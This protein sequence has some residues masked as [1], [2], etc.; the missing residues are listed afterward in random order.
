MKNKILVIGLV[1][2][3]LFSLSINVEKTIANPGSTT[4]DFDLYAGYNLITIPVENNYTASSLADNITGFNI[5]SRWDTDL[6]QYEDYIEGFSG[7]EHD[8]QIVDGEGYYVMVESN[9]QFSVTG[10]ELSG[11]TVDLVEE[12]N[13]LGWY[14]SSSTT[15]SA[16]FNSI[17]G[18]I[19]V[20]VFDAINQVYKNYR[21]PSDPDFVISRGMGY[22]VEISYDF[23]IDFY[24]GYNLITI[25]VENDYT[26]STLASE[27]TGCTIVSEWNH[28]NQMYDDYIVGFSGP[29][30]DFT[31]KDGIGYYILVDD[32]TS[33]IFTG[34]PLTDVSVSIYEGANQLGWYDTEDTTASDVLNSIENCIKVSMYDAINQVQIDYEPTGGQDFTISRGMGYLVWVET[35]EPPQQPDSLVIDIPAT[36]NE[37]EDF[38]VT[39]TSEG[40]TI[41]GAT[42]TFNGDSFLTDSDGIVTLTA[43]FADSDTSYSITASKTG[44][45]SAVKSITVMDHVTSIQLLSPNGGEVWS[46]THTILWSITDTPL[47]PYAVT[48]Q[49]QYGGG[50]WVTIIE[51]VEDN[52]LY[53]LDTT[54]LLDGYPYLIKVILKQDNND[55]GIYETTISEDTS[56]NTFA[57]D[58]SVVHEGRIYG[59]VTEELDGAVIPIENARVYVI[60]SDENDVITSKCIFTDENGEYDISISSGTFTLEVSKDSYISSTVEGIVVWTNEATEVNF[61]LQSGIG[62]EPGRFPTFESENSELIE[63]SIKDHKVGG[64]I[65]IQLEEN[66]IDYKQYIFIY[67]DVTITPQDINEGNISITIDGDEN[68]GGRT[69][70]INV[71]REVFG[72]DEKLVI[73]YDGELIKMA[74]DIDD[75]LNPNDDGSHPE[76]LITVGIN[77]TQ[78]LVSIPHFSQHLLSIFSE[79]VEEVVEEIMRYKEIAVLFAIGIIAIAAIVMFRKGKE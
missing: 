2:I 36:V 63:E 77:G 55:D 51:D 14:E 72:L 13:L 54:T 75:I 29:E 8:F 32:D 61:M 62:T 1:C 56:D 28:E 70:V 20:S 65:T 76:Y 66:Q 27:I 7:S 26:A 49:Y 59:I 38:Q 73:E 74:D 41:E 60:I 17:A 68:S 79:Y 47:N 35:P 52:N 33:T 31:I 42:V 57:I 44:Y 19:N 43:P 22:W 15:A 12:F 18:C 30:D 71:A 58:N 37:G 50:S 5:V 4:F 48:V 46:N 69:I 53:S 3:F 40:S 34:I 39:I 9:T 21:S 11:V 24:S 45:Q 78:I 67:N 64:E 23:Q 10:E 16:I 6:Q 25:P